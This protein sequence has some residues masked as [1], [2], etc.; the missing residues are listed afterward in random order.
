MSNR[1]YIVLGVGIM[2]TLV[3]I[4]IQWLKV[5]E[6]KDII[7]VREPV[8]LTIFAGQST[9]DAGV[10]G[11]INEALEASSLNI[12]L[13]WEIVDWGEQFHKGV[14]EKHVRGEMPD[15][16]IG[17]VLD[18]ANYAK[19][20]IIEELTVPQLQSID[21][22][23]LNQVSI[24]G[25]IYGIPYNKLYQGVLYN[26]AIFDRFQLAIPQTVTEL[27]QLV[28]VLEANNV[29]PF[30]THYKEDWYIANITMQWL[31]NHENWKGEAFTDVEAML[32]FNAFIWS[33]TPEVCR[34]FDEYD[35]ANYFAKGSGA[36]Y[37]TG[38]WSVQTIRELNQAADFGIF[39]FPN[40]EGNAKLIEETN[41]VFM[42][43]SYTQQSEAVDK[44]L[45]F[46]MDNG[47]LRELILDYTASY[48]V[49]DKEP[50]SGWFQED[51]RRYRERN[52]LIHANIGNSK[53]HWEEQEAYAQAIFEQLKLNK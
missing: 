5:E 29:V 27:E 40:Q 46:I 8:K 23:S 49:T 7:E 43:S 48:P 39:P 42:K 35:A 53:I 12:E 13:E 2:I 4:G 41:M 26:K 6:K 33:H 9:T 45:D 22:A 20:G 21:D 24:D 52:Q 31:L 18:V 28:Q 36:M 38:T 34:T 32:A 1:A 50:I 10:E 15:I 3:L 30:V 25:G 14:I 47:T 51:I 11:L 17:K 44:F 19:S 16:M 37:M